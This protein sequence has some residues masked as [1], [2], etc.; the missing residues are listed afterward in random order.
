M[1]YDPGFFDEDQPLDSRPDNDLLTA[2]GY[3]SIQIVTPR[4][5][6]DGYIL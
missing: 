1:N 5:F 3:K 6:V 4:D 2:S